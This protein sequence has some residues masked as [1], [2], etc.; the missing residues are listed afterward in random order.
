MRAD[1]HLHT[2]LSDGRRS[3]AALLA[4]VQRRRLQLWSITDHD[5]LAGYDVVAGAAGLLPGIEITC[6][7]QGREAHCVA[8]AVDPAAAELR[9]LLADIRER[10][11][12]RARAIAAH[13]QRTRRWHLV[14]EECRPDGGVITRSHLAEGLQ[15]A[16][17]VPYAAAA[18][19]E[20]L[21][22]RALAPLGAVDFPD[23]ATVAA[24]VRRAGGVLLLAHPVHYHDLAWC[25]RL[26]GDA[27]LD[28]WEVKHP[29]CSPST[30][31][32]LRRIADKR[33]WWISCG[34]D[35]HGRQP[36]RIGDWRLSAEELRPLAKRLS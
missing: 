11:W 27:G 25:E 31:R 34:S 28:G 17:Y 1:M 4:E 23:P 36:C 19:A 30:S 8:L 5:T 26:V 29:G 33:G 2:D 32:L 15:R 14:P 10:R 12:Q 20:V 6:A 9:R 18:F 3:P 16:G 21:G 24:I 35:D 13:L 22:D 7:W